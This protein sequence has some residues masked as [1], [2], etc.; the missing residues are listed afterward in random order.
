MINDLAM[1]CLAA[2]TVMSGYGLRDTCNCYSPAKQER[3]HLVKS[4]LVV[5]QV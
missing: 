5:S 2:F 4:V 3:E 1:E